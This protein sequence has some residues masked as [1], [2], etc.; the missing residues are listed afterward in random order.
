M[1]TKNNNKTRKINF[2]KNSKTQIK[3]KIELKG[4]NE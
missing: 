1:E 2:S 3:Q 4:G